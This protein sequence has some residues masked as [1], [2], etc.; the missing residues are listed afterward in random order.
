MTCREKIREEAAG[1]FSRSKFGKVVA[2]ALFGLGGWLLYN[3]GF[4][5]GVGKTAL[6]TAKLTTIDGMDTEFPE[7]EE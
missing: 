4:D 6:I 2:F 5:E 3:A 1:R 7:S